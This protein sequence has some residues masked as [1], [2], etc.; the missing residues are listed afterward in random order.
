MTAN[1]SSCPPAERAGWLR[2]LTRRAT[3]ASLVACA[4]LVPAAHAAQRSSTPPSNVTVFDGFSVTGDG[5][6]TTAGPAGTG[7]LYTTPAEG[8][9]TSASTLLSFYPAWP[10]RYLN[11]TIVDPRTGTYLTDTAGQPA[12]GYQCEGGSLDA[13]SSTPFGLADGFLQCYNAARTR[14]FYVDWP[15]FPNRSGGGGTP[16]IQLSRPSTG[17]ESAATTDG[18]MAHVSLKSGGGAIVQ[19]EPGTAEPECFMVSF[20]VEAKPTA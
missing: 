12:N 1:R 14:G 8:T 4:A 10:G 17:G 13:H 16:C 3:L 2:A 9:L 11:L 18:C 7:S 5:L 19:T 20:R 15:P 6:K